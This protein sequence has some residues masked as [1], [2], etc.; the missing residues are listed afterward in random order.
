MPD[1]T[2]R[3]ALDG[4]PVYKPGK[5]AASDAY[6]LSSNENPYA[7]LPGV[8]ERATAELGQMNRYPDAGCA[9]LYDALA[10]RLGLSPDHFA[11]GTG[12]VAVLFSLLSAMCAEGDEVI[13]AWRSFEAY[14]IAV[15]LTGATSVRVP[16]R[17][18]AT[19]DLDAMADAIT[20]RT[21]VVLVCTPNNPTGP[22]VRGTELEAFLAQVPSHV[23]IVVDEAYVEFVREPGAAK[24]LEVLAAHDNVVVLRTFSKAY[25]LAGLR[26]GYAVARP[27]IAEAIRKATPP[28]S[29]S[30]LAQSAAVASLESFGELSKRID[31]LVVE[32]EAMVATL[33]DQGWDVPDA[34]GNF[35]WLPLG[36]A[37]MAF[38]ATCGPVSVR[39]F[40]GDGVRISVGDASI[41]AEFLAAAAAWANGRRRS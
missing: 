17:A 40:A 1:P 18:D 27:G 30:T 31:A 14:P 19:H 15:E 8:I 32:R 4:I 21:K 22:V 10:V 12:S 5:P 20:E 6:K 24:G 39:P 28:F 3:S 11:A 37:A 9:A 33:R 34:Q 2:P 16:L 25:G 35:I 23:L 36:D 7:P 41:N 13:Y 26:V 29:V 38:A